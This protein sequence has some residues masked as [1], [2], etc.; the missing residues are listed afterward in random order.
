MPN[1]MNLESI[2][3]KIIR[4]GEAYTRLNALIGLDEAKKV[5][6]QALDFYKAQLLFKSKGH[7]YRQH[8]HTH[9]IYRKSWNSKN[10]S[11]KTICTKY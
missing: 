10:N 5:I 11:S 8:R 6:N 1:L 7:K 4:R 2:T 3:K 9:G